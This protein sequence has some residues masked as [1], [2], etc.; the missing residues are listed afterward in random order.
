M[1]SNNQIID[2]LQQAN[3]RPSV[4]RIAVLEYVAN[5]HTHPTADEVF[6]ALIADFPTVSRTTVYNSLHTLVEAGLLKELEIESNS[7]RY[8]LA[9]QL[10]HSHFRCTRCGVI[11]DMAL[12]AGLNDIV[13]AGFIVQATELY[14][15]GIC[16]ECAAASAK[17]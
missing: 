12:P 4:H 7:T 9:R 10:P 8:D 15:S 14:F 13:Q 17:K 5:R 11:F 6:T 2:L 3:I 1:L 16:P